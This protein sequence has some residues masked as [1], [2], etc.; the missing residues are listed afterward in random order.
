VLA[1]TGEIR[2]GEERGDGP[3]AGSGLV[4]GGKEGPFRL[5]IVLWAQGGPHVID[6]MGCI[7]PLFII[8]T[9]N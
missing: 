8:R 6:R 1:G 9:K 7:I 2:I 3:I 4:A 5:L